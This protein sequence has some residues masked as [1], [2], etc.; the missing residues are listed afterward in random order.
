MNRITFYFYVQ[1]IYIFPCPPRLA[2]GEFGRWGE[3]ENMDADLQSCV[4]CFS[5]F[6]IYHP[7]LGKQ[8]TNYIK[9]FLSLISLKQSSVM[10]TL[11]HRHD[12]SLFIRY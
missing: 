8:D 6:C 2:L 7:K 12:L 4:S 5:L 9:I 1:N 3:K 10:R 11:F